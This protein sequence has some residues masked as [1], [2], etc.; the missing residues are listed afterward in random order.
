[1]L[2]QAYKGFYLRP[3][4]VWRRVSSVRSWND[5]KDLVGGM[6]VLMLLQH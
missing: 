6:K 2:K 4:Y 3:S 1:M 5:V